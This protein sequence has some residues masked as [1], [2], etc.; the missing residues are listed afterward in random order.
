[1]RF[2]IKTYFIP[3]QKVTTARTKKKKKKKKKKKNV[4]L[5]DMWT[6]KMH[7]ND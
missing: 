5:P 3:Q 1:M 2:Y 4:S 7:H 6:K